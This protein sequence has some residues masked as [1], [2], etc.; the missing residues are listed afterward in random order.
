MKHEK[1]FFF[2]CWNYDNCGKID[3]RNSVII[4][5]ATDRDIYDFGIVAGDNIYSRKIIDK[6]GKETKHMYD[7]TFDKISTSLGILIKHKPKVSP[8]LN[9]IL[10][11]HDEEDKCILKKEIEQISMVPNT[12]L[13]LKNNRHSIVERD[14]AYYIY[15]NTN[16][17]HI[18]DLKLFLISLLNEDLDHRKWLIFV[19]HEPIYSLKYKKKKGKIKLTELDERL[20][21]IFYD[22]QEKRGFNKMVYLCADTHNFQLL[23]VRS[24]DEHSNFNLPIVVSGTGG[25]KL[26]DI[27]P[28][29]L[30]NRRNSNGE[31]NTSKIN[32]PNK[33]FSAKGKPYRIRLE[34]GLKKHGYSSITVTPNKIFVNFITCNN[35]Y[36]FKIG[37]DGVQSNIQKFKRT[38]KKLVGCYK[39]TTKCKNKKIGCEKTEENKSKKKK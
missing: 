37:F 36:K 31:Y 24:T 5:I 16:E 30:D 39:K 19:G 20:I 14:L 10:G 28:P 3:N 11:N 29:H 2:G 4:M 9:V 34:H 21:Q 15:L 27:F 22:L 18:V 12:R 17:Q 26:D 32:S 1:F 38:N 6:S 7:E 35:K 25:A 33:S 23:N 8:F 13:F